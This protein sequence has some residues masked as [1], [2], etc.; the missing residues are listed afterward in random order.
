MGAL[1]GMEFR[2]ALG[3]RSMNFEMEFSAGALL[4]KA[5]EEIEHGET[6]VSRGFA[7]GR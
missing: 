6:G 1:T 3:L 4:P 2:R 7:W 5:L